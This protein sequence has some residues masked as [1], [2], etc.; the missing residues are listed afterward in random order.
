MN[1]PSQATADIS[2]IH[3]RNRETESE[4][5][6]EAV[7]QSGED[8]IINDANGDQI[9]SGILNTQKPYP[10]LID[11]H[12]AETKTNWYPLRKD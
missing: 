11:L 4:T 1:A 3:L 8:L 7:N 6:V 10:F 2:G 9:H 12:I 5:Q